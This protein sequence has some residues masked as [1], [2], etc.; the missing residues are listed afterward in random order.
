MIERENLIEIGKFLKTHALD[1]E[2]NAVLDIDEAYVKDGNPLIVDKDGIYVP[3]YAAS[4]RSKGA[5]SFLIR[6]DGVDNIDQ[7]R[8]FVNLSIYAPSDRCEGYIDEPHDDGR[9]YLSDLIGYEVVDTDGMKSVGEIVDIDEST[10]NALFICRTPQGEIMIPAADDLIVDVDTEK[11]TI[12][13]SLPEGLLD[14]IS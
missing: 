8:E 4:I 10:V 6:L 2:L 7:A 1:G 12:E 5:T 14:P 9:I 13:M 3:F 11:K